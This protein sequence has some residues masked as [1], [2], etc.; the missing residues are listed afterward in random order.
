MVTDAWGIDD[1]YWDVSGHWHAAPDHTRRALRVAMGGM[2]DI[3]DP[4]PRSRLVW[5]VRHGT[6]PAIERPA[7]IVLEDG[8]EL[9]VTRALP[10]DLPLGYHDLH[11]SDG[12]PATRL[13]VNPAR[14]HVPPGPR[15]WGFTVQ[16]YAARSRASWGMGD[17]ADLRRIAGWS[18]V[19]GAGFCAVSPLHAPRLSPAP[20]ASP[21]YPSSRLWRNPLHLRIEEVPGWSDDDLALAKAAAA[22]RALLTDRLIDRTKVWE[23]KQAA[24]EKLFAAFAGDP[25]FDHF[26][27]AE[28]RLLARYATFCAMAEHHG[29]HW[30]YWPGEHRRPDHPG[31]DRFAA[32]HAD[33]VRFHCWLQWLL[34]GQLSAAGDEIGLLIDVAVGVDPTGY[35]AWLWQDVLAPRVRVGAPPDEFNDAGQDWGLPPFVPWKL[36]ASGYEPLVQTLR[37]ALRHARGVRVDHVMGLFRLFWIPPGSE[38]G[39]GGYVRFGGT[40]LLDVLALESVRAGALVVGEDLGT[41]ESETRE[42]LAERGV[43]SYGLV[44]FEPLPPEAFPA[45]SLAAVTT[46]DLPTVAGLWSGADAAARRAIGLHAHEDADADLRDRL[47]ALAGV[48][49]DAPVGDVVLGVHRRLAEGSSMLVSATIDDVLEVEERPNHPGTTDQWPNWRLA[50]P[51]PLEDLESDARALAVTDA[52]TQGRRQPTVAEERD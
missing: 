16:L 21:Y 30:F 17:L 51:V 2:A 3:E 38:P 36:R 14:C 27:A 18:R 32:A 8:T 37:A 5:F 41:V 13:I 33:R 11:P 1:G 39:D 22:G 50:L 4:P 42:Q 29:A 48:A 47:A 15:S 23:L 46:H 7:D 28:G 43:L 19:R 45:Q 31:V 12:G 35:D 20:E 49:G 40:E 52:L 9:R 24:L 44:W 26:V 25:G 10:P 6:G 34:D